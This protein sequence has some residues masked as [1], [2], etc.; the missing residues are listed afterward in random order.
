MHQLLRGQQLVRQHIPP[1]R[2]RTELRLA[3]AFPPHVDL[4][5]IVLS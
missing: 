2:P 3:L 1:P 4:V 5:V